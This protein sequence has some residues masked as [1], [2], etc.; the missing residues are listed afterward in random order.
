MLDGSLEVEE[1]VAQAW[2]VMGERIEEYDAFVF[3]D[4]PGMADELAALVASGRKRATTSLLA[5]YEA[6]GEPLPR[7]GAYSVVLDGRGEPV[8]MIRTSEVAVRAFRDVDEAFAHDEVEGDL[9]LGYWREA[10][11]SFFSRSLPHF[12]EDSP[13][14][15]ER[16]ELAYA[17]G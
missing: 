15:C 2:R 10:H 4:S 9:S 8:C 16:F 5:E 3:G 7:V 11:R 14:V 13:V 1:F 6:E 12:S 17:P